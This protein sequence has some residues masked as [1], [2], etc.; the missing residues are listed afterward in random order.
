[1]NNK[2]NFDIVGLIPAAGKATRLPPLPCSKEIYP[3]NF[4]PDKDQEYELPKTTCEF[5]IE[6]FK[7]AGIDKIY[8]TIRNEKWDIP[9]YLGDGSRLSVNIA[10]VMVEKPYGAPFSLGQ[11][12]PFVQDKYI[13]IGYPD[14]I[15]KPSHAYSE[16]IE[17][18]NRT[19]ADVVLGLFPANN[20]QKMDMVDYYP[21]G[22]VKEIVIKPD[23]THLQYA[24]I[25]AIWNQKFTR[26]MRSYLEDLEKDIGNKL[27]DDKSIEYFV[28]HVLKEALNEGLKIDSV[29]FPDGSILD[30]GTKEDLV[31]AITAKY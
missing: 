8:I 22:I 16:I 21:G 25:I 24:W 6:S 1:M 31:K 23:I 5:L 12:F 9:A 19:D 2:N 26:F 14:I 3:M 27:P 18:F 15:F 30:I 7:N 29:I 28:G 17:K 11:A 10:Y 20:P 13:A 4:I